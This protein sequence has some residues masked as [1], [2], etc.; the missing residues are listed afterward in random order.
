VQGGQ[1]Q[2]WMANGVAQ[3]SSLLPISV[4][5]SATSNGFQPGPDVPVAL[6]RGEGDG[7]VD[8]FYMIGGS[9][10]GLLTSRYN[11]LLVQCPWC[12]E[13][14]IPLTLRDDSQ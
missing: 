4:Y 1:Y 14:F 8:S 9:G 13:T 6:Y 12:S 2:I 7:W 3:D 5:A 11:Q 10:G